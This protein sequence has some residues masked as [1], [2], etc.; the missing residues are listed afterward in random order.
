VL[1]EVNLTRNLFLIKS[2]SKSNILFFK[3]II[4]SEETISQHE[5]LV[6]HPKTFSNRI[7]FFIK[8]IFL[9]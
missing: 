6:S 7:I 8:I 4:F 1:I 5:I 2:F 9:H 3:M